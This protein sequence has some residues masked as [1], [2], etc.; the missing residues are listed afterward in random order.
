MTRM[1]PRAYISESEVVHT[2]ALGSVPFSEI[3]VYRPEHC[4]YAVVQVGDEY[5]MT[6]LF[7]LVRDPETHELTIGDYWVFPDED[8]AIMAAM[9]IYGKEDLDV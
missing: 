8:S 4:R 7:T 3:F 9:M 2:S 6:D 5:W 1:V